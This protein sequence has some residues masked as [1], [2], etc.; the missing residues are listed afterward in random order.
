MDQGQRVSL[1]GLKAKPELN[2]AQ[3]FV[4]SFDQIRGR[5]KVLLDSGATL[6]L[7]EQNLLPLQNPCTSPRNG[8]LLPLPEFCVSLLC[9]FLQPADLL[10]AGKISAVW[11]MESDQDTIWRPHCTR[12]WKGRLGLLCIPEPATINEIVSKLKIKDLKRLLQIAGVSMAGFRERHEFVNALRSKRLCPD[13]KAFPE[14]TIK[15]PP[16]KA[17]FFFMRQVIESASSSSSH[18]VLSPQLRP[19]P[20]SGLQ[21]NAYKHSR[22]VRRRAGVDVAL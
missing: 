8:S 22:A 11:K 9:G 19:T 20:S 10:T 15:I 5:Y 13:K 12:E 16:W 3:G 18:S 7:R 1:A 2:D 17:S 6:A 4:M 14:W 21:T